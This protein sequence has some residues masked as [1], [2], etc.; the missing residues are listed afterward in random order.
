MRFVSI[1]VGLGLVAS[2][3]RALDR[4]I[5]GAKVVVKRLG[6]REQLT[7]Q[8]KDPAFP[9]PLL[10]TRRHVRRAAPRARV[11]VSSARHRGRMHVLH[12]RRHRDGGRRMLQPVGGLRAAQHLRERRL[13]RDTLRSAVPV[14]GDRH[15]PG[16]RIVLQEPRR[17]VQCGGPARVLLQSLLPRSRVRGGRRVRN[18]LLR[19]DR[20]R[21]HGRERLLQRHVRRRLINLHSIV[22]RR[23][24]MTW[25]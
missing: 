18:D 4:P 13:H 12:E 14:L 10:G 2:S 5:S 21:M 3:A 25:T 17:R 15:V 20:R 7:F 16:G 23:P 1:V 6:G 8:S 24:S 11:L 22:E 9:F 19:L